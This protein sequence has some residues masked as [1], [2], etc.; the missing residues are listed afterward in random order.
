LYDTKKDISKVAICPGSG[1]GEE[2]IARDKGADVFITGDISHDKWL[3][4]YE[5]G[6]SGIFVDHYD[7]EKHF[8]SEIKSILGI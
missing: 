6:V 5:E 2:H 7:A 1:K 8:V 3:W 4:L